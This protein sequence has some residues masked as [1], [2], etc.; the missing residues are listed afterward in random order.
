MCCESY[1]QN[2][3]AVVISSGGKCS[4]QDNTVPYPEEQ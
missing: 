3:Y 4:E 2:R 1:K